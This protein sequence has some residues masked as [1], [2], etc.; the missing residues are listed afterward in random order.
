V[1]K[2]FKMYQLIKNPY[3]IRIID[4]DTTKIMINGITWDLRIWGIDAPEKDQQY[5][6]E[7]QDNLARLLEGKS[8]DL[9]VRNTDRYGR[10]VGSIYVEETVDIGLCQILMGSAWWER[11]YCRDIEYGEAEATARREKKGLWALPGIV[12]PWEFRKKK[13]GRFNR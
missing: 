12:P 1:E 4:G 2:N 9:V 13:T 7:A 6:Y 3:L 8:I 11:G 5:W 10:I